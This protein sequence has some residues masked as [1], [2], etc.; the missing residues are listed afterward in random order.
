MNSIEITKCIRSQIEGW[1]Y[2]TTLMPVKIVNQ[3]V[4]IYKNKVSLGSYT[5]IGGD[6]CFMPEIGKCF[7]RSLADPEVFI[8]FKDHL[9]E[10]WITKYACP[11]E[12]FDEW[13]KSE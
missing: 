10:D 12:E 8:R 3:W 7:T 4:N 9:I 13:N 5:I 1:G 6:L 11:P 2:T